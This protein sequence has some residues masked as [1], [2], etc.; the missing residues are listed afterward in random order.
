MS[1]KFRCAEGGLYLLDIYDVNRAEHVR[2]IQNVLCLPSDVN[3]ADT[4]DK[5]GIQECGIDKRHIQIA[6][7]IWGPPKASIEGT[8]V[9][10]TNKIPRDSSVITCIPPTILERYGKVALGVDVLHI[11]NRLFI[12]GISK[13]I[14][15]YQCVGI[16]NKSATTFSNI[17]RMF[18]S[19]YTPRGFKV[20]IVYADQAFES[21]RTALKEDGIT[22]YCCDANAEV[23]FVERGIQ[24]IKEIIRCI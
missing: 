22:L 10:R 9:Q 15:Y 21:C 18:K 19:N 8:A 5:R 7:I 13:H 11:N 20:H 3:F 23:Q 1:I 16:K 17:I 2:Y 24:F 14:K 4:L 12:I 6:N